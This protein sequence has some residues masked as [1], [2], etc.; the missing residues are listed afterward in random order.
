MLSADLTGWLSLRAKRGT[1]GGRFRLVGGSCGADH[2]ARVRSGDGFTGLSGYAGQ[3]RHGQPDFQA[4]TAGTRPDDPGT[5]LIPLVI[6]ALLLSFVAS[7]ALVFEVATR[8]PM[9]AG[10]NH[11]LPD[12][13]GRL[14]PRRRTPTNSILLVAGVALALAIGGAIGSGKQESFQILQTSSG[15]LYAVAYLGDS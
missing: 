5:A 11:F 7:M 14:H 13:F 10:W 8:L 15:V 9:V 2:R 1:H 3:D 12:W 4:L 6:L